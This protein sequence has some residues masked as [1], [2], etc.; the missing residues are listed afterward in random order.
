M[1]SLRYECYRRVLYE[2]RLDDIVKFNTIR[3]EKHELYTMEVVK[4]GLSPI[5][6][7]KYIMKDERHTMAYGDYRIPTQ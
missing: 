3:S 7:K 2:K 6:D 4:T 1:S 5:D